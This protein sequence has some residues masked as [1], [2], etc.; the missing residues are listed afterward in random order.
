MFLLLPRA[1]AQSLTSGDIAGVVTDP[2]GAAIPGAKVTVINTQ[3]GAAKIVS[4]GVRGEYRFSLL[5]PGTYTVEATATGFA[6]SKA[7]VGV[8]VGQVEAANLSLQV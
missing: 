7:Q 1:A 6:P 2:S 3:T 8:T 5:P 4:T